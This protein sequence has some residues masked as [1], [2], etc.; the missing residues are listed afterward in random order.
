M[1]AVGGAW[2][3]SLALATSAARSVSG[4]GFPSLP[5]WAS[6]ALVAPTVSVPVTAVYAMCWPPTSTVPS[7]ATDCCGVFSA[8]FSAVLSAALSDLSVLSS[9]A[10][11]MRGAIVTAAA[12]KTAAQGLALRIQGSSKEKWGVASFQGKQIIASTRNNGCQFSLSSQVWPVRSW[13]K[14]WCGSSRTRRKPAP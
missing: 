13:P 9:A 6:C 7:V 11:A 14:L 5:S 12:T 2:V 4:S 1:R 10:R 8:D 3:A